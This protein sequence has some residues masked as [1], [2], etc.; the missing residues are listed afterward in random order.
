M[1]Y[2]QKHNISSSFAFKVI[3]LPKNATIFN[4]ICYL[5]NLMSNHLQIVKMLIICIKSLNSNK[6]AFKEG[7]S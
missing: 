5:L 2:T 7:L 4:K 3:Y 6:N 1:L